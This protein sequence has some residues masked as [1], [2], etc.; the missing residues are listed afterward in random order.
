[1]ISPSL[2]KAT[3]SLGL[4]TALSACGA[5]DVGELREKS[6]DK[7]T[8]GGAVAEEYRKFVTFEADQMM[9]WQDAGYF[10]AKALKVLDDPAAAQ[11]E[12]YKNWDIDP[13]FVDDL[14]VGQ[15]RLR[16]AM[17]LIIPEEGAANLAKAITSFDCWVEQ[18]EEG[19]QIDH[20]AAC[21]T[22][23]NDALGELEQ[24]K[25]IKITDAGEA[26]A[27]FVVFHELDQP[28][29]RAEDFVLIQSFASKGWDDLQLHVHVVGH[30]DRSG[31]HE[32]NHKLSVSRALAVVNAIKATWPGGY[33]FSIEGLG[34]TQPAFET[35]DGVPNIL[36]RR[37]EAEVTLTIKPEYPSIETAVR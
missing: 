34:E 14:E 1:M 36:N 10:A 37:T 29:P 18:A 6:I 21:Q 9:D 15:G 12:N 4:I 24:Q 19:W 28:Q 23:F 17:R 8:F 5:Y 2:L 22:S 7:G 27:K 31:S 25:D 35:A 30:A 33:T 11:P 20:I 13:Q 26:K 3:F 32:Y 16:I